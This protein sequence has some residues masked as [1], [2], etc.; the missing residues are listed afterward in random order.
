M[1]QSPASTA[2]NPSTGRKLLAG[3]GMLAAVV[4]VAALGV[5]SNAPHVD[6]WY[7]DAQRVAW[8]P[9]NWLFA[10]AWSLLYA[11]NVIAGYLLWRRGYQGQGKPSRTRPQLTLFVTQL[12]LNSLWSPA[13]F[14][15]YP[16]IGASAWWIAMVIMVALIV[17]V[18]ALAIRSWHVSK[19]VTFLQIP[20]LAWLLFASTLNAGIIVLN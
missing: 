13:F 15:L 14:A 3:F 9:P 18:I 8:S 19:T 1:T 20:Y 5:A 7:A 2:P 16:L 6:G 17:T 11:F 10:P 4:A 12:A